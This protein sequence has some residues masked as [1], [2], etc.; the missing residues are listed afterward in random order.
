MPDGWIDAEH[1]LT[2]KDVHVFALYSDGDINEPSS[3]EFAFMS[4]DTHRFDLEE[5]TAALA[6]KGV[7]TPEDW[8]TSDKSLARVVALGVEHGLI[9]PLCKVSGKVAVGE[10]QADLLA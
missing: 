1:I 7:D 3:C 10:S 4:D 9:K 2:Y 6:E 8:D 5:V